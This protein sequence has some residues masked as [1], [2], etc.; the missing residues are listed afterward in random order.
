MKK[1]IKARHRQKPPPLRKAACA[2]LKKL[3]SEAESVCKTDISLA[4]R[5]VEIARRIAM[6]MKVKIPSELKRRFCNRCYKYLVP[7]RN[8]RVRLHNS[9]VIS[10]CE[11]CR[12][13]NKF[14]Y[15]NE[16]KQKRKQ[17][18]CKRE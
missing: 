16:Q 14:G 7:G 10:F 15:I 12:K 9:K 18:A 17:A 4:D 11:S 6:K 5:Y 3:F 2:M 13:Y 8:C 1:T